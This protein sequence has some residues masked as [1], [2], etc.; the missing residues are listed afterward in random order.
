MSISGL[1]SAGIDVGDN[2][3]IRDDCVID[4]GLLNNIGTSLTIGARVGISQKCFLQVSGDL[5]IGNDVIIGP[6]CSIFTENHKYNDNLAPIKNQGVIRAKTI[7]EE[8]VWIGSNSTILAG[9]RVGHG[10]IIAAGSV[11][12]KDVTSLTVVAGVPASI[13]RIRTK[14]AAPS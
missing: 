11:V 4:T 9:V 1:A 14:V 8:D 3:T 7:I 12:T 5:I 2:V 13:I 10:A 6:N